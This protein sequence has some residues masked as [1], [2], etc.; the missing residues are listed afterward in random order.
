MSSVRKKVILAIAVIFVLSTLLF[1]CGKGTV[2]KVNGQRITREEYYSR[3]E[4]LP[5]T[6]P[7]TGRRKEA[8]QYVLESMIN[9]ALVLGLAEK[10]GVSPT[11]EQVKERMAEAN[12][13]PEFARSIRA[14]GMTTDQLKQIMEVQQALFNLQTKGVKVSDKEVKDYYE[15]NK[16]MFTIDESIDSSVIMVKDKADADK[17]MKMLKKDQISF[18]TVARELS[19]DETSKQRG[20]EVYPP[21]TKHDRRLPPEVLNKLFAA[22]DGGIVGPIQQASLTPGGPPSYLIFQV[23]KHHKAR[24]RTLPE[25]KY[26]I[27]QQL[28]I[29][30][31][32]EDRSRQL[33]KAMEQFRKKADIKIEVER[34]ARS[35][36]QEE[37]K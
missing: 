19:L 9:E 27:K 17:A 5:Y 1:G 14:M 13:D 15:K 29:M 31:S 21:I 37:K 32:G 6:D 2:A 24:T 7:A 35:L 22:S 33:D 36:K 12:K 30:K 10:E 34:Y 28:M 18:G 11:E 23:R 8:G 16:N 3:L 4:R 25:V 26:S 20:G